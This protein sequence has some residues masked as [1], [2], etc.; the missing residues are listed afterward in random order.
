[1]GGGGREEGACAETKTVCQT[2]GGR[3]EAD[4]S[5]VGKEVFPL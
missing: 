3:G 5:S 2:E 1:M 4:G